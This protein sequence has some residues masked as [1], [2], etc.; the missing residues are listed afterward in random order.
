[1]KKLLLLLLLL[2]GAVRGAGA[3]VSPYPRVIAAAPGSAFT[4]KEPLR[5]TFTGTDERELAWV[6]A[7]S[8]S[9]PLRQG[10]WRTK[11]ELLLAALPTGFYR[12]QFELDGKTTERTFLVVPEPDS[13]PKNKNPFFALD[14]A[15][16]WL[17]RV[18]PANPVYEGDAFRLVSEIAYRC[19]VPAVRERL[20]WRETEPRANEFRWGHYRWNADHL[21]EFGIDVTSLYHDAPDWARAGASHLPLELTEVHRYSSELAKTFTGKINTW[22]FWNEQDGDAFSLEGA[23]DYASALKAASLGFRQGAPKVRVAFGGLCAP[24][25]LN[26]CEAFLQNDVADYFDIFNIHAYYTIPTLAARIAE[27]RQVM[28]RFGL[29]DKKLWVTENGSVV[30]GHAKTSQFIPNQPVH[31][32]KQELLVAEFLPKIMIHLQSL[33]VDRDYFF[34]LS[35]Y[36][37]GAKDWGLLRYDYTAKPGLA[38]FSNLVAELGD[39][40]LEGELAAPRGIRAWLYRQPDHSQT[41]VCWSESEV[42]S[43]PEIDRG[44]RQSLFPRS[45]VIPQQTGEYEGSSIFGTPFRVNATDGR[46]TLEINRMPTYLRGLSGLT[47]QKTSDAR[48]PREP[49]KAERD[50]TLVFRVRLSTDFALSARRDYADLAKGSGHFVLELWNLS[51]EEKSGSLWFEGGRVTG[52]PETV[53]VPAWSKCEIPLHFEGAPDSNFSG[54]LK[55]GGVFNTRAVTSLTVPL[56]YSNAMAKA[57]RQK[58]FARMNQAAN[59]RPN[60]SGEIRITDNKAEKAVKVDV[61]FKPGVDRWVYPEFTLKSS[62]GSL[63]GAL[64][65]AFEMKCDAPED[66]T[67]SILMAVATRKEAGARDV[68][69]KLPNPGRDWEE[70]VVF[71]HPR[72][73]DPAQIGLLRLGLNTRRDQVSF[74]FRNF[75]ILYPATSK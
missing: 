67:Q 23:W 18:N 56:S 10:V 74:S 35:P 66:T 29:E 55:V 71:F 1:M 6:L 7:D 20:S 28:T 46:I 3:D 62:D 5:F 27:V 63:R 48:K 14:S 21:S 36:N 54:K 44:N 32:A 43:D 57:C 69:L 42:D 4:V 11:Q 16:S 34:V 25:I 50:L 26:Y 17:C 24:L 39:A 30:E 47:P 59:W 64:G 53:V 33:G 72:D 22:E 49:R 38:A 8:E 73:L 19:G 40:T 70:R 65:V 52:A 75:R 12:L 37:E 61:T 2:G 31:D 51:A 60:A 41:V 68:Y 45:L 9:R 13:R 58:K 15:Q